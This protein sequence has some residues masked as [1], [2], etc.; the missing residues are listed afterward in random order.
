MKPRLSL[1]EQAVA[2][3]EQAINQEIVQQNRQVK[4]NPDTVILNRGARF[5]RHEDAVQWEVFGEEISTGA[6]V[7]AL[8]WDSMKEIVQYG[9]GVYDPI[10]G[11]QPKGRAFEVSSKKD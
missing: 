5:R 10:T 11:W 2:V 4:L 8:V 3:V 9:A 1:R 7:N 6:T